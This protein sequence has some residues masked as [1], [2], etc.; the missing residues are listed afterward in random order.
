MSL[1]EI[2]AINQLELWQAVRTFNCSSIY[3]T[4]ICNSILQNYFCGYR[5]LELWISKIPFNYCFNK[6]KRHYRYLQTCQKWWKVR[7]GACHRQACRKCR[8][9][10]IKYGKVSQRSHWNI[11]LAQTA[12][13]TSP[14]KNVAYS[15]I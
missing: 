4:D 9:K 10:L 2:S 3:V 6:A 14:A 8:L 13:V 11:I 15:Q 12:I 7:E 5:P 1:S